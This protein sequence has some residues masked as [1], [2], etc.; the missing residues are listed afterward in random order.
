MTSSENPT[1]ALVGNPNTGKSTLFNRLTG[2]SQKVGNYPGITVEKKVGTLSF[3]ESSA[4]LIDLPGTYSL[5]PTSQDEQIVIDV[6]CGYQNDLP[7]PD[8]V[9]CIADATNL[10]R[11]LFFASQVA[12]TGLPVVIALNMI[13][14][15]EKKG[16][17]IDTTELSKRIG[18]PIVPTVAAK[19]HGLEEL[20][21]TLE[22]GI[23]GSNSFSPVPWPEPIET[24]LGEME[25]ESRA[26]R[27]RLLFDLESELPKRWKEKGVDLSSRI[28]LAREKV[29][30]AGFDPIRAEAELRYAHIDS[31]LEGLVKGEEKKVSQSTS[32]L[33]RVL[34]HRFFGLLIFVTLMMGVFSSIYWMA[35][36]LMD[37]IDAL[38]GSIGEWAGGQLE[39]SPVLQS[40]VVDGMIAG[41]GGVVIFL[42]Q[43]LILFFFMAILE[44]SGY[45]A[46]AAFLMDKVFSWTGLNGKSFVPMLSSFACAIP[47]IMSAR[48]IEDPKARITTVLISPLMSCSARLPVY[49]LLIGAF[50]EPQIGALGA[51]AV[52]FGM[53]LLGL[54]IGLPVA[55]IL[56]RFFLKIRSLPFVLELPSYRRPRF[57]D[58]FSRMYRSGKEFTVRAGTVIFIFSIVI[59]ALSY[60]P[61]SE[62]V[63]EAVAADISQEEG[64]SIE[65]AKGLLEG[66][67]AGRL[68]SAYVESSYLGRVG[69]VIQ[70]VFALAGFDWKITVG[71]LASFPA[72]EVIVSTLGILYNLG[73]EELEE[74][75]VLGD[76]LRQAKWPDGR[77]VF[78]PA[79]A[80]SIM[81]FFALCLQCG[82]TVAIIAREIGWR[83]ATFSFIYMTGLAWVGAVAVFQIGRL[84]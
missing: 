20:K 59:W 80:F 48:T 81:V 67:L 27:V 66:D 47:A 21:R 4:T 83:W 53:H 3:G 32:R 54:V 19:G 34:T 13:D 46:R 71:V 6:L 10:K 40:L 15:A 37:G 60:F 76:R 75:G 29:K 45:M 51:G 30:T 22:K 11:N 70:P 62:W 1:V 12:E 44:D 39:S 41:V 61:R 42:P 58:V 16:I 9:L 72:R 50:V 7:R 84:F 78:T 68:D 8:A 35:G 52:L 43:I 57:R 14:E 25:G 55:F 24:A 28:A 82:A 79:V 64:I 2:A 18:V 56:N 69:K 31:L 73:E 74:E 38:F 5:A 63:V 77:P 17:W 65:E 36:P 26:E 23:R 49:V 33:D